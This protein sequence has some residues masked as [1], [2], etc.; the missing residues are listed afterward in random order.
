MI[1]SFGNATTLFALRQSR[2]VLALLQRRLQAIFEPLKRAIVLNE[3][4]WCTVDI[5]SKALSCSLVALFAWLAVRHAQGGA[6][7]TTLMLGSLYMVWEYASQAGGVISAVAAHFQTFAR[8]QA[9]YSSADPIRNATAAAPVQPTELNV[10]SWQR[11]ELREIVFRHDRARS[12]SP[13]LDHVSLR[14]ERGKRYAL[15]GGSGSGKSTLLRVLAGLYEAERIVLDQNDGPAIVSAPAAARFLRSTVTLIP[16]DAEVF[17]GTLAENLGLCESVQG[18]PASDDYMRAM[19]L[20]CASEFVGDEQSLSVSVAERGANWSGGQRARVALAR[21]ILAAAGSSLVLL[22]EP[23]ASLDPNT[24]ARVYDNLFRAFSDACVISSVHR[25]N[26]LER[27][28]E[29]LVMQDGRLVAQGAPATLAA[30]SS[31]FRQL[32]TTYR[33]VA[34]QDEPAVA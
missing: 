13:T 3:A 28:D 29:V 9:D 22:D 1:D 26:L 30:T 14:L 11:C 27:F 32:L 8:Q 31:E 17:E 21:G 19:D 10:G 25:L 5:A 16:Q 33:K 23:T 20:S 24:E 2:G 7:G 4:K 6:T 15:I 12:E 18:P 34:D